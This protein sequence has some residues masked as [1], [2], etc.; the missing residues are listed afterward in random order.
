[1]TFRPEDSKML[2]PLRARI[3]KLKIDPNGRP[4]AIVSGIEDCEVTTRVLS[5]ST[6]L[7][8]LG[9]RPFRR[10][11]ERQE[12]DI[13]CTTV[14]TANAAFMGYA[15]NY[16]YDN[17][18]SPPSAALLNVE[19]GFNAFYCVE[20]AL[21]LNAY[22]SRFFSGPESRWN[23]LDLLLVVISLSHE[24]ML[25]VWS[26][27][28]SHRMNLSFLRVIRL[29]KMIR[30]LRLIRVLRRS[31]GLRI[32]L[33]G[34]FGAMQA[35][36]Y[37]IVLIFVTTYLFG[38]AILQRCTSVLESNEVD[39]MARA[40]I[41]ELWSS[42][43]QAML[44][45]FMAGTSGD[46]WRV[47]AD[48][49]RRSDPIAYVVF[50]VYLAF[51]IFVIT[52]TLT[53]LYVESS[54]QCAL[55]DEHAM[56]QEELEKKESHIQNLRFFFNALDTDASGDV[57]LSEFT[58]QMASPQLNAFVASLGIEILDAKECFEVLSWGGTVPVDLEAFVVGCIKMKGQARSLDMMTMD[59]NIKKEAEANQ[60][61]HEDLQEMLRAI[62]GK[63]ATSPQ[64][65]RLSSAVRCG[66]RT[67]SPGGSRPKSPGGSP[68]VSPG[69]N[70]PE[71]PF[72]GDAA[73][74]K[75][76]LAE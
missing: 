69:S 76:V 73:C 27:T 45:L 71:S 35:L 19:R 9:D 57:S 54:H 50:L 55:H 62:A 48:P 33:N 4:S 10:V 47:L 46:S 36:F 43:P 1:M 63:L 44:S 70:C 67:L 58:A 60:A 59:Y 39:E 15:A 72:R 34:M 53:S 56:V 37:A 26:S 24:A 14:I 52:N 11:V 28:D 75:L 17:I 41:D 7:G 13:I 64:H 25:H 42:V 12:F 29:M 51:F 22:R 40:G 21:R 32:V 38:I 2:S 8:T 30:L 3:R 20:I 68:P 6:S 23:L 65:E 74:P 31:S 66:N 49:L 5:R 16:Y 61:R 18:G